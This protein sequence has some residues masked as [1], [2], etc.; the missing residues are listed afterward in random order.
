[1]CWVRVEPTSKSI[2]YILANNARADYYRQETNGI[3]Y[4]WTQI[5]P[6]LNNGL[7]NNILPSLKTRWKGWMALIQKHA[8]LKAH[9]PLDHTMTD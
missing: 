6:S 4:L 3:R 8:S 2:G 1:M 9:I 5:N 7:D